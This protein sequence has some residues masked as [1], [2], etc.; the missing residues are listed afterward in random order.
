MENRYPGVIDAH[1]HCFRAVVFI[2]RLLGTARS[3]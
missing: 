3:F 2:H 1:V